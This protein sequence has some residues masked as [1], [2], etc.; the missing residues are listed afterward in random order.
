MDLPDYDAELDRKEQLEIQKKMMQISKRSVSMTR[1]SI[2]L[3]CL[4]LLGLFTSI[5]M[6]YH[7]VSRQQLWQQEL[8]SRQIAPNIQ[9]QGSPFY[10]ADSNT[11]VIRIINAG[12]G[13]AQNLLPVIATQGSPTP[14]IYVKDNVHLLNDSQTTAI[15]SNGLESRN[16][17]RPS[18]ELE[19]GFDARQLVQ[20]PAQVSRALD[21]P[22]I[23][24]GFK[25]TLCLSY[26]DND[27]LEYL[28]AIP[29][30]A[31]PNGF[32][33]DT[34]MK[35]QELQEASLRSL[36]SNGRGSGKRIYYEPNLRRVIK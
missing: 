5:F 9:V 23:I 24:S 16:F 2:F 35:T 18:E 4:S 14:L 22:K 36:I 20:K 13:I 29:Y 17:I 12:G 11:I 10:D 33:E 3:A 27:G 8:R 1:S 31:F 30:E 6:N 32:T 21:P 26:Y 28:M 19:Y 34:S 25:M 7:L 15:N